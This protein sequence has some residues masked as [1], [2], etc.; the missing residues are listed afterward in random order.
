MATTYTS[1]DLIGYYSQG[2]I[3]KYGDENGL[4]TLSDES[5]FVFEEYTNEDTGTV[6]VK[7]TNLQG[8]GQTADVIIV[9]PHL[10]V[11]GQSLPVIT[12][13]YTFCN[14]D[15][16]SCD[17]STIILPNTIEELIQSFYY[18][19]AST[20]EIG[21]LT[22][23]TRI[24]DSLFGGASNLKSIDIPYNVMTI[25]GQ[26]FFGC[27][28]LTEV[29]R[30]KNDDL[31]NELTSIYDE[32]FQDC[33][34]LTSFDLKGIGD[35][36]YCCFAAS[37][38]TNITIPEDIYTISDNVFFNCSELKEVI[39]DAPLG[40]IGEG[41][42]ANT[43]LTGISIL[44]NGAFDIG[45][46]AFNGCTNLEYVSIDG[47]NIDSLNIGES[48]FAGCISL[49]DITFQDNS[50]YAA[51]IGP[52]A[53]LGCKNLASITLPYRLD[54]ISSM[55]FKR[56]T[57]LEHIELPDHIIS[58]ESEA[59][60]ESGITS[61]S[62]Q[63]GITSIGDNAFTGSKLYDIS[64]PD[65][66]TTMGQGVF[67]GCA[68]LED[69]S[70]FN[71]LTEIPEKT[72]RG[73]TSLKAF[74][75]PSTITTIAEEAFYESALESIDVP[76]TVTNL[77][78]GVFAGCANL[79]EVTGL[80]GLTVIPEHTFRGCTSLKSIEIPEGIT[81]ISSAFTASG[82]ESVQIPSTVEDMIEAFYVC[83]K[84]KEVN[85]PNGANIQRAFYSCTALEKISIPSELGA[86]EGA[87][88]DCIS[89]K[90]VNIEEGLTTIPS[91]M[92]Y[93]C[94]SLENIK[95][96]ST[97]TTIEHQAF[98][99]CNLSS[100]E[101]GN[102]IE[103]VGV[104]AFYNNSNLES[105]NFGNIPEIGE[106][107]V[108]KCSNLK[109]MIVRGGADLSSWESQIIGVHE[110]FVIYCDEDSSAH[111][112]AERVGYIENDGY[113]LFNKEYEDGTFKYYI[114]EW[115]YS[116]HY[117]NNELV[118]I[119]I[120]GFSDSGVEEITNISDFVVP[121]SIDNLPVSAVQFL[122]CEEHGID[123][124]SI[125]SVSIPNTVSSIYQ[126][127]N[128]LPNLSIVNMS[129]NIIHVNESFWDCPALTSIDI[130]SDIEG[131]DRTYI[132]SSFVNCD[133]L[134]N[135]KID[136]CYFINSSFNRCPSLTK[137]EICEDF[138]NILN[139]FIEP[140]DNFTIVCLNESKAE[141]YAI[142]NNIKYEF[143]GGEDMLPSF[144]ATARIPVRPLNY[145]NSH[146]AKKKELLADYKKGKLFISKEDG[147][148]VEI[149][150]DVSAE[151]IKE[152]IQSENVSELV[153]TDKDIQVNIT[154]ADG[155]VTD[156]K[157]LSEDLK[158]IRDILHTFNILID[159]KEDDAEYVIEKSHLPN[160]PI[161]K[162]DLTNGTDKDN[163]YKIPTKSQMDTIDG[164]ANVT[165]FNA[166]IPPIAIP[167][168]WTQCIQSV[169][170]TGMVDAPAIVDIDF[171]RAD[172]D[173][174]DALNSYSNILNQ[175]SNIVR[176][177]TGDN[178]ILVHCIGSTTIDIPITIALITPVEVVNQETATTE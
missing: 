177:Q 175:F 2:I 131:N 44:A 89:L 123:G 106:G 166:T 25:G 87:F 130:D 5:Y 165:I 11:G 59:F 111:E 153:I 32:A 156:T 8:D 73:C 120:A 15:I 24:D 135:I 157:T 100:I 48:A 62:M 154:N 46:S 41:A 140:S 98:C 83:G 144:T 7:I 36:G 43:A 50:D 21:H 52:A 34:S 178:K 127:F 13:E 105:I 142:E 125:K 139:S 86:G 16:Y 4:L 152:I 27:E 68:K 40:S 173:T 17:A 137:A 79:S 35:L 39:I 29:N 9:P 55:L 150:A 42:F 143:I 23:L 172:I 171:S 69:V 107:V 77:G 108:D 61:I 70:G 92:F 104:Q 60:Y 66:V 12:I 163:P 109:T 22:R 119:Q 54:T 138:T 155:E 170:I 176:I 3:D 94:E 124:G 146:L 126:S 6:G 113:K 121:E 85:I 161:D 136:D 80:E 49:I 110:D 168:G 53:F 115:G 58:I 56:C 114:Q 57:S 112:Y 10:T 74:T 28:S 95:L 133:N 132:E 93:H 31:N 78:T 65:S 129:K 149:S 141:Q 134:T 38:L 147:E 26:A 19:S 84:L 37:G 159:N 128:E 67:N 99:G 64:I 151:L 30:M 117:L 45:T 91:D 47:A 167:D 1:E 164:K 81:C 148:I 71:G 96:P 75:I 160:I 82:I 20:V 90:E 122:F 174:D 88:S 76:P 18:T 169:S 97:I 103:Y 101:L 145:N 116:S 158:D 162:L 14:V 63:E 102:N 51:S 118:T 72:F 33:S